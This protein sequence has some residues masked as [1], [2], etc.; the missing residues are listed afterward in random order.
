M[1][2]YSRW[3]PDGTGYD[4]FQAPGFA[5]IGNDLPNPVMPA[6][7]D[8]GVPSVE[9]GH[10]LPKMARRVGAGALPVGIIAPMDTSRLAFAF[11]QDALFYVIVGAGFVGLA[12]GATEL[13]R[14]RRM[15]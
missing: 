1:L 9:V 3:R 10:R 4:Y 12:W 2:T 14:S 6:P 8:L 13:L 11:G 5:A 7:T 15:Q